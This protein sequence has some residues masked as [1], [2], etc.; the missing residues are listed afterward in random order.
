[1]WCRLP[2]ILSLVLFASACS[3]N[4]R[5]HAA[6]AIE[7][8]NTLVAVDDRPTR[9]VVARGTIAHIEGAV[10]TPRAELPAPTRD[11]AEIVADPE[12]FV[13]DAEARRDESLS[14]AGLLGW[15]LAGLVTAL[16]LLKVSGLGGPLVT[17]LAG[18]LE[19]AAQH[20]AREKTEAV[21]G[22]FTAVVEAIELSPPDSTVGELKR[23]IAKRVP[24]EALPAIHEIKDSVLPRQRPPQD[25]G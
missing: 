15:G 1:M 12:T 25:D 22:G 2:L 4:T 8:V 14:T 21:R 3:Q 13:R 11:T 24:A 5:Q 17:M 6:D 18:V 9:E 23:F 16:G 19:S 10:E 20:R 7:G